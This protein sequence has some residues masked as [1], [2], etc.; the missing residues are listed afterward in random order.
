M[1]AL[2]GALRRC[3][4]MGIIREYKTLKPNKKYCSRCRQ[5]RYNHPGL[6]ERPG[7]D[8]PVTSKECWMYKNAKVVLKE[9]WWSPY[10]VKPSKVKTLSCFSEQR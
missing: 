5:D 2:S 7:I 8:A 4:R 9:V 1:T 6:C 10:Q 3:E